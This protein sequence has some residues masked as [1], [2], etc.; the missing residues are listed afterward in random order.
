[1]QVMHPSASPPGLIFPFFISLSPFLLPP[2]YGVSFSLSFSKKIGKF[3]DK[4][5]M[6]VI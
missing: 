4:I 3:I 6:P 1:V 5:V 2:V